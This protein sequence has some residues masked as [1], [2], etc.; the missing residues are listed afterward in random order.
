MRL[1][2]YY[3]ICKVWKDSEFIWIYFEWIYLCG[4]CKVST[5]A[6]DH[7]LYA[8][9]YLQYYRNKSRHSVRLYLILTYYMVKMIIYI[10][11]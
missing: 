1:D 9:N 5:V 10:V 7:T 2:Y 8:V 3:Y 11:Y 4:N 6:K